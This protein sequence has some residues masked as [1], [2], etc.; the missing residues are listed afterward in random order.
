MYQVALDVGGEAGR[1]ILS[2]VSVHV[3]GDTLLR[4]LR[5]HPP[6]ANDIPRTIGVDDWAIKKGR[7][8]GTIIVNLESHHVID[9]LPDRTA[10]SLA[11]WLQA[12]P[13]IELVTRDRSTDYASMIIV[14][15]LQIH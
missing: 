6:I 15:C 8:Y 3:S 2:H 5:K 12:H 10:E 9:L 11:Q 1:R 4:V 14:G 13:S 7:T